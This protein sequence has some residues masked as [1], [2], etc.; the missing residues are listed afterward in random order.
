MIKVSVHSCQILNKSWSGTG[1]CD[2]LFHWQYKLCATF[3][4]NVNINYRLPIK[5]Y[6]RI[7]THIRHIRIEI[8]FLSGHSHRRPTFYQADPMEGQL[9]IRP[10]PWKANFLSGRSHRRPTLMYL[11][12][13]QTYQNRNKSWKSECVLSFNMDWRILVNFIPRVLMRI[14]R[15]DNLLV[16]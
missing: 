15:M 4:A 14:Y 16:C 12:S 8:N 3:S 5:V 7:C 9:F 1:E 6:Y 11:Y 13:Y 2:W 10:I